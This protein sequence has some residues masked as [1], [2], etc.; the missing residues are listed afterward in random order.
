MPDTHSGALIV[1]TQNPKKLAELEAMIAPYG[2]PVLSARDIGLGEVEETGETFEDNAILKAV[3][4]FEASGGRPSLADD[5]GLAVD[6]LGGAPGVW[7]ARFAGEAAT[8]EANN[9]KLVAALAGVAP[10][11]R[12]ARFVSC[13]ALVLPRALA[14]RVPDGP[15]RRRSLREVAADAFV[16]E[17]AVPGRIIDEPRGA[18]GFGYDPHF[19]YEPAGCTFAE[20]EPDAKHAVSHRGQAMRALGQLF[21]AVWPG[22]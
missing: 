11:D 2:R 16:V 6:A 1:A 9:A 5:S 13:V 10:E 8:D 20:L 19:W 3:A 7:S 14:A 17:G 21:A 15:W 18:G 4:G 12:G 22:A